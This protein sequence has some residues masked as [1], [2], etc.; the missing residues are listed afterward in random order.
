MHESRWA[1]LQ[2]IQ[3]KKMSLNQKTTCTA[4]VIYIF[5]CHCHQHNQHDR[6]CPLPPLPYNLPKTDHRVPNLPTSD[7]KSISDINYSTLFGIVLVFHSCLL[8]IN[9]LTFHTN[10]LTC[11]YTHQ[12][13]TYVHYR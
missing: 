12:Q 1:K 11:M 6:Q 2:C 7:F 10:K 5:V 8:S 3:M 13:V 9:M 4:C